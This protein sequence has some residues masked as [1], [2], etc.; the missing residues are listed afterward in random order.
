MRRPLSLVVT[1]IVTLALAVS[2]LPA[3]LTVQG[4]GEA[5]AP[6]VIDTKPVRGEELPV[7]GSVTFYFDEPMDRQSVQAAFGVNPAVNG[8]LQWTDDRTATFK[9]AAPLPRSTQYT[10]TITTA[11]KSRAG[12]PLRDL[13][14]LRAR[15]T[16][17]LEVAQVLPAN[18]TTNVDAVPAIT[19]IFNRP[20]VPL[21]SAEDQAKLPSPITI[22]PGVEGNGEWTSTAVY[23]FN[24][25]TPL[26]GGKSYTVI[27]RKGL[28]DVTGS[29]LENDYTFSFSV[30]VPKAV[31]IRVVRED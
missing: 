31:D 15:T 27:V 8:S 22:A 30:A 2:A 25:T 10:F 21:M 24:P 17:S 18:N 23:T 28:T 7:D 9:A 12:A 19:V 5:I 26:L 29:P 4:A 14:T 6:Q 1:V 16:G 20:V 3:V 11:A 13:F